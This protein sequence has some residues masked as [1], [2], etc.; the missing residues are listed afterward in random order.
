MRGEGDERVADFVGEAAGDDADQLEVGGLDLGAL[1]G[2][3]ARV[4]FEQ[5][6]GGLRKFSG[7]LAQWND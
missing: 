4:I 3:D 7:G 5:E 1:D 6:Q 2:G